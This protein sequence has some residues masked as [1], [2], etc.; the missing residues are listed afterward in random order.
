MLREVD[1]KDLDLTW[2]SLDKECTG[3]GKY[4]ID[5]G[6]MH[7]LAILNGLQRFPSSNG[8]TCFFPHRHEANI[9][10]D[11]LAQPSF[12][13][14]IKDLS[15][16]P[17]PIGIAVDHAFLTLTI[18]FQFNTAQKMQLPK[19][20][21]YT[22]TPDSNPVYKDG[23]YRHLADKNPESPLK[24]LTKV[25]TKAIHEAALEAYPHYKPHHKCSSGSMPQ[26]NWYDK[27][28]RQMRISLQKEVLS[29]A[30]TQKQA[31]KMY[32]KIVRRKKRNH[33]AQLEKKLYHLFLSQDSAEAWKFFQEHTPPPAITSI[34]VWG[35]YAKTLYTV[36]G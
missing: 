20:I 25:L 16:S 23:L 15:T 27:E 12:L 30:I 13:P 33:L 2:H 19:H 36:P 9:V 35:D 4:L 17:R 32:S 18:S 21:R 6:T 1:T 26:N 10:D 7:G 28:C 24:E 3:Y 34:E 22:F 8:F 11:I 31:K 29:G 5:M 14:S